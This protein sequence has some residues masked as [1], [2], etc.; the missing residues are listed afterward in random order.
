METKRRL[1]LM[2]HKILDRLYVNKRD[3]FKRLLEK[4]SPLVG[5]DY[6]HIFMLALTIGFVEGRRAELE[7]RKEELTRIEYLDDKEKSIIKA[8]AVIETGGLEV[9]LDKKKVYAVAEE[10]AAGGIKLLIQKVFS[11]EYGSFIKRLGN[12]L[13]ERLKEIRGK[14]YNGSKN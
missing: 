5:Y 13:E 9:L 7:S 14:S 1:F 12:E 8:I 3:D 2:E 4:D 6:K 10:Y 11:G